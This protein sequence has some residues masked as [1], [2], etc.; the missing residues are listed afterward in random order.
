L[1]LVRR[2]KCY[3]FP[4]KESVSGSCFDLTTKYSCRQIVLFLAYSLKD[5]EREVILFE[6]LSVS[7]PRGGCPPLRNANLSFLALFQSQEPQTTIEVAVWALHDLLK[8]SSQLPELAREV[9]MNHIP[10]VVTSLLGLKPEVSPRL[11]TIR[12]AWASLAGPAF[13]FAHPPAVKFKV[14]LL[15]VESFIVT[16]IQVVTSTVVV[17]ESSRS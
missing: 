6:W 9:A 7:S 2:I 3:L 4:I 15:N 13:I 11:R 17:L 1:L 8:Y 14:Y 12:G 10:T 16:K 5:Y